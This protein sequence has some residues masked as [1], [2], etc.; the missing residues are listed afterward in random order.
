MT[1]K[2]LLDRGAERIADVDGASAGDERERAVY[3]EAGAF[4]ATLTMHVCVLGAFVSALA[5]SIVLPL[6]LILIA[7]LPSYGIFWYCKRRGVDTF[8]L[9][10]R[11]TRHRLGSAIYVGA[12]LGLAC[13]AMGYTVAQGQ[14]LL[15]LTVKFTFVTD[16]LQEVAGLG[17]AVGGAIGAVLGVLAVAWVLR[18]YRRRAEQDEDW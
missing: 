4:A 16:G 11:N 8:E 2:T 3:G 7:M 18:G 12:I 17:M 14:G 6:T 13:L 10:S 15:P 5:G 1:R 9:L